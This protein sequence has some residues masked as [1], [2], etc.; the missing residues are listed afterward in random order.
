MN[1][2]DTGGRAGVSPDGSV[3]ATIA[4]AACLII[5]LVALIVGGVVGF[6]LGLVIG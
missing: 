4:A 2:Q 6:T 5:G 1:G 3:E